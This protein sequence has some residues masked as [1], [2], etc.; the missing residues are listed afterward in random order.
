MNEFIPGDNFDRDGGEAEK[1]VWDS[2]KNAFSGR[3]VLGYSRYPLFAKVGQRL[4]EPDILLIDKKEGLII[5]EVKGFYIEDIDRL[6]MNNWTMK[7][8]YERTVNPVSQVEDYLYKVKGSFDENRELRGKCKGKIFVALPNINKSDFSEKFSNKYDENIFLFKGDL[9]EKALI[10]KLEE[11]SELIQGFEFNDKTF[12]IAASILGHEQNYVESIEFQLEKGTKGKIYSEVK[13]K[14]HNVDIQQEKIGKSIAPGP[15]RIRG[16]A[17][18]GKT[19]LICQKAANM[20][21]KNPSWKIAITFFTQSLYDTIIGTLDMYLKTFSKG[22]INYQKAKGNIDVLHA[23]GSREINGLYRELTNRNRSKFLNANN[24]NNLT[25]HRFTNPEV[26][27][28]IIS[29]KL[30]EENLGNLEEVYDA[31]FIDE[32][33]DLVGDDIYKYNN[34]QAFY[35]MA[36]KSIKPNKN[37]ERRLIW[38]YDELQSL[39]DTKIPSSKELFGD[40]NLVRGIYKGGIKKSEIMK[41]CYRT[42]H[43]IL[44]AA[45]SIGMGFYRED[46]M[47]TG[48][49][50][51]KDWENIGYNVIQGDF[52]KDG[53]K[54]IL[55]RPIENSPNPI[56]VVYKGDTLSFQK[57]NNE[58]LMLKDLVRDIKNDIKNQGLN[59]SR[60]ILVINLKKRLTEMVCSE[61]RGTGINFYIPACGSINKVRELDWRDKRPELFWLDR[62]VTVSNIE[63]A[64][65]NEAAMVYIVGIEEIA[66]NENSIK[67]R[68]K[69]FTAMTRGKCFVKLM[70]VGSYSLYREIEKSIES[71]GRFE[72]TYK[73]P[74]K[75]S[76]DNE[77]D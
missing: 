38:A 60:D 21:L 56:N 63:R 33:Q 2:I 3:E 9:T 37:G 76:N 14:L 43:Q 19:L 73:R 46:G 28:N 18:S 26:S 11:S 44:T 27:I 16:I 69:L 47:L 4:K 42:P 20:Y 40:S 41:K 24:V 65:G 64:K 35:Y 54:I 53:N 39:N 61:L 30:L 67:E 17:G 66:V 68:N 34:K 52:K 71:N 36:Y 74:K 13:T 72:F 58:T 8:C 70:G 62:A 29:K 25:G 1:K 12:A 5:V 77:L 50:T 23:W 59:P 10:K 7:N 57:Y 6:E 45:H 48:Y 32:G 51:K 31:I 15:Q 22:E 55:E 49:T 75:E